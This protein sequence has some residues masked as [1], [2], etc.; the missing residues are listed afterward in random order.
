MDF[1]SQFS[2]GDIV[3]C[4]GDETFGMRVT[5]IAF[6]FGR[7]MAQLSWFANGCAQEVWFDEFRLSIA[8]TA[9]EENYPRLGA[10]PE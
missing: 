2:I 7:V 5:G 6:Y 3:H 4:D 9:E 1:A 8:R 10:K